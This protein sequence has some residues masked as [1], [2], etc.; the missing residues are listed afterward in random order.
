M[1]LILGVDPGVTGAM[2]LLQDGHILAVWDHSTWCNAHKPYLALRD[3]LRSEVYV[4]NIVVIEQQHARA[5]RDA[6]G[7]VVQGIAST[8]NY[9]QHYGI[10]LGCLS[11]FDVPI[12]EVDPGVWKG[13]MHLSGGKKNK[14]E[15][16]EFARKLW[17][18]RLSFF[19]RVQDHG[20]AEAA[21]L[22][23]YGL[24]FLPMSARRVL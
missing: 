5:T 23:F 17:P 1:S 11:L 7:R 12:H 13:N 22:A 21:L 4:P 9:A 6:H 15:S 20:R 24:R 16:L 18:D 10:V 3:F 2:A 14:K 19:K 8:W